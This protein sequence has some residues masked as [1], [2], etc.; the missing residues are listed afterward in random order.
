MRSAA[1]RPIE[2]VER[3]AHFV[4]LVGFLEGDLAHEH[5]AILLGADQAGLLERT[6]RLAHRSARDAEHLGDRFLVELGAGDEIARDDHPLE[7]VRDQ[8]RQRIRLQ[9]RDRVGRVRALAAAR[10]GGPARDRAA[11]GGGSAIS[12]SCD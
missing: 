2:A 4:D 3:G 7:L 1:R 6:E 5:A 12:A 8:R 11:R 10:C 9:Q